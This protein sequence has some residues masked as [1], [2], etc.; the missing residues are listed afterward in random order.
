M[1]KVLREWIAAA[2]ALTICALSTHAAELGKGPSFDGPLGLQLYSLR[3]DFTKNVPTALEK[4]KEFGFKYVELAG[5][6]N[7]EPAK[8][9]EL[10]DKNGFVPISGHFPFDRLKSDPAGV[11]KDAKALGLKYAGC[12]WI[13]HEG[14][15]DEKEAREAIRV[16]NKAGEELAKENIKFFYH[17]H[18]YE[19][20]KHESGTLMDLLVK[21][22][23]PQNVS[24]EMD[25][26]WVVYPGQ[27]PVEQ[28]K[29]YGKRWELMHLKDMK[30]SLKTGVQTGKADVTNDVA[31][32]TG[33]MNWLA[34]L[35]TAEEIGVKWYFIE[36]EAPTVHEQIPQSIKYLEQVKY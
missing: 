23:N 26:F 25:V 24:F 32:G 31:L 1:T 18:G 13:T 17:V 16:F 20:A 34:I 21:E 19:W 4:V 28:L 22:T 12:A 30:K 9:K 11:A 14:D 33:Q 10:L 6:Y 8:F 7:M 35:K 3:A 5:T 36:D 27:D 2:A 15:F 29:K